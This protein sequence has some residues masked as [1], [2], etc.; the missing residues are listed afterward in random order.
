M[1]VYISEMVPGSLRRSLWTVKVIRY[2]HTSQRSGDI[3]YNCM[4]P[5]E[6]SLKKGIS[7]ASHHREP[8]LKFS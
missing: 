8:C 3:I 6:N 5:K 7:E 1:Y 4:S 2:F